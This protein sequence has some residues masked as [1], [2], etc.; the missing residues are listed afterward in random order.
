MQKLISALN[1]PTLHAP[2]FKF[3]EK[4]I[5]YLVSYSGLKEAP[6]RLDTAF[7]PR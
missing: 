1:G 7:F 3:I 2:Y 4:S 5:K 6:R